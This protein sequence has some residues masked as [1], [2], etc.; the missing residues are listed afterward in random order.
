MQNCVFSQLHHSLAVPIIYQLKSKATKQARRVKKNTWAAWG[1]GKWRTEGHEM[2]LQ[3]DHVPWLSLVYFSKFS[4]CSIV[5][6]DID[7]VTA[8]EA[9]TAPWWQ[10]FESLNPGSLMCCLLL[11]PLG[12]EKQLHPPSEEKTNLPAWR[13]REVADYT[14]TENW[15]KYNP[16]TLCGCSNRGCRP[17][18]T[19]SGARDNRHSNNNRK[20]LQSR[21]A[22]AL[23]PAAPQG[24]ARAAVGFRWA[25]RGAAC[26]ARGAFQK[27]ARQVRR[28]SQGGPGSSRRARGSA[29]EPP[30]SSPHNRGEGGPGSAP[31]PQRQRC[32]SAAAWKAGQRPALQGGFGGFCS[33]ASETVVLG[34]G[35]WC[36]CCWSVRRAAKSPSSSAFCLFL[37]KWGSTWFGAE[38]HIYIFRVSRGKE[39]SHCFLSLLLICHVIRLVSVAEIY[40]R[41]W[42]ISTVIRCLYQLCFGI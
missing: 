8:P 15:S 17:A 20:T 4:L 5:A 18:F 31:L 2:H 37:D 21:S 9:T 40:S 23:P 24:A 36:M 14:C 27:A 3:S 19:A 16:Y 11:F 41:H 38:L 35:S 32:C 6:F 29:V 42:M 1:Q 12:Q 13:S 34:L 7:V 25:A 28:G 39:V 26:P 10:R 30:E 33:S 22:P